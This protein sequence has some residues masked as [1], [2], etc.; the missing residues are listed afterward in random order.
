MP[1]SQADTDVSCVPKALAPKAPKAN[2]SLHLGF[3]VKAGV[4]SMMVS[5]CPYSLLASMNRTLDQN[6]RVL[7]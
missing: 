2:T 5:T 6:I 7:G 1:L 4:C 3:E